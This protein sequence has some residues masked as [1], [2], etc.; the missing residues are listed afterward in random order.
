LDVIPQDKSLT[1]VKSLISEATLSGF[2]SHLSWYAEKKVGL[3]EVR[4]RQS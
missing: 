1:G 4:R 2:A 3:P